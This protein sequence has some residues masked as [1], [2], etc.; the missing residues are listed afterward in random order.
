M[1]LPGSGRPPARDQP[2]YVGFCGF[3]AQGMLGEIE[4]KE[5]Y[6]FV[7]AQYFAFGERLCILIIDVELLH[8]T[9]ASGLDSFV[10]SQMSFFPVGFL[11]PVG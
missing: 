8:M 3:S 10:L 5:V 7:R 6:A 4:S 2:G 11:L 9:Y 1:L